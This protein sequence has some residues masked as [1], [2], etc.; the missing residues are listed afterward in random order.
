MHKHIYR[1]W[2][3]AILK[4]CGRVFFFFR[5]TQGSLFQAGVQLPWLLLCGAIVPAERR[6]I[7]QGKKEG[8]SLRFIFPR[9]IQFAS[10]CRYYRAT[11]Y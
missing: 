7:K 1:N 8:G 4:D 3:A 6:E 5:S 2:Q 9:F 10:L 11:V